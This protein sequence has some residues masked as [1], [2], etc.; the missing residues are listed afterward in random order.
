M[1]ICVTL[2]YLISNSFFSGLMSYAA[3]SFM[4]QI[5]EYYIQQGQLK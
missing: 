4:T 5:I 1:G 2:G 3:G